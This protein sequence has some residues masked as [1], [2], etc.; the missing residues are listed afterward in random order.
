MDPDHDSF[1]WKY[2]NHLAEWDKAPISWTE[3]EIKNLREWSGNE[4]ALE[5]F[6]KPLN[7]DWPK[8]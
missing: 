7:S 5:T 3:G 1:R 4:K 8:F 6:L 2:V